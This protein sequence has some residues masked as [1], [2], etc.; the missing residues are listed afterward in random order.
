[1]GPFV[2]DIISDELNLVVALLLGIAFGFVLEQAG[3]S[4]SRRLAGLFYGYDFTVLRVF[5]TAAMTAMLGVMILGHLGYLDTD[6][7]YVNPMFLGPAIVGGAIMGVGF[8][9]GG[10]CPGTSVCAAAIGKKDGIAFIIGGLLGVL[11][12]G[13]LF[14][15]YNDFYASGAMGPLKVSDALGIPQGVFAMLLILVAVGAFAVTTRIEKM[16]NPGTPARTWPARR[17]AIA[18]AGLLVFVPDRKASLLREIQTGDFQRGHPLHMMSADELAF[19]IIDR[20]PR[21]MIVDVRTLADSCI[22]VLPGSV[23]MPLEGLFGKEYTQI[24]GLRHTEHVFVDRDG[25]VAREAGFLALRLGYQDI[26]VLE[27]GIAGLD[28]TV[29]A[30]KPPGEPRTRDEVDTFRFREE[31][32]ILLAKMIEEDRNR[33]TAPKAV[34]K[35]IAGGC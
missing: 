28:S 17:H 13:E 25:T 15:L 30:F 33:T 10:Y 35:K 27:G 11:V 29:L 21:L 19:R 31:A 4:S 24:L 8:I 14:P 22:T 1:M 20:D 6:I 12:F 5:F 3:F 7:I 9:L 34:V 18:A 23:K 2:P 26:R 16:V 32:K